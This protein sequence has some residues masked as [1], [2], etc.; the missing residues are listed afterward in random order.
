MVK[1]PPTPDLTNDEF[2]RRSRRTVLLA[3][4]WPAA[5]L[6]LAGILTQIDLPP[7]V[8]GALDGTIHPLPM[9]VGLLLSTATIPAIGL[10]WQ[11]LIADAGTRGVTVPVVTAVVAIAQ[12]LGS[13]LPGPVG[14]VAA[15]GV[16]KRRAGIPINEALAAS[17]HSRALGLMAAALLAL[18]IQ[19][20]DPPAVP[21]AWRQPLLIGSALATTGALA[22]MALMFASDW[23]ER[24]PTPSWVTRLETSTSRIAKPL[25]QAFHGGRAFIEACAGVGA[26]GLLPHARGMFWAIVA[27]ALSASATMLTLDG[28]GSPYDTSG[29]LFSQGAISVLALLFLML[30]GLAAGWDAGYVALLVATAGVPLVPAIAVTGLLRIHHTIVMALGAPAVAWLMR[31]S[32]Y[33]PKL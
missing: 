23:L 11:A 25:T 17:V 15:A 19:L 26:G 14:E 1:E 13:A 3:L 31:S 8:R 12:L 29:I 32:P 6:V 28:L 5:L 20:F 10:R 4:I 24:R 30:P 18:V 21:N 22:L 7:E 9:L 2:L 16:L 27:V 33:E